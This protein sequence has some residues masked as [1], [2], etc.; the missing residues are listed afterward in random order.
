MEVLVH[1]NWAFGELRKEVRNA[2][3]YHVK[4]HII[5]SFPTL[6]MKEHLLSL[7]TYSVTIHF[8]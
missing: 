6:M 4:R 5:A 7:S 1:T 8:I 2:I 3:C